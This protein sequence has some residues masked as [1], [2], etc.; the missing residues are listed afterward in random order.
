MKEKRRLRNSRKRAGVCT[1]CGVTSIR[2]TKGKGKGKAITEL[3]FV[4]KGHCMT[5]IAGKCMG[6]SAVALPLYYVMLVPKSKSETDTVRIFDTCVWE[7]N[8]IELR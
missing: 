6:V 7:R 8:H 4:Y 3:P 2:E 5:C 1:Y